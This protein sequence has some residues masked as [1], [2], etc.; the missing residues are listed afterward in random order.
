MSKLLLNDKTTHPEAQNTKQPALALPAKAVM[1]LVAG[2]CIFALSACGGSEDQWQSRSQGSDSAAVSTSTIEQAQQ[3]GRAKALSVDFLSQATR[4]STRNVAVNSVVLR[5]ASTQFMGTGALVKLRYN[6]IVIAD[7]EVTNTALANIQ[8]RVATRFDGGTLDLVFTNASSATG[9]WIR[10]MTVEAVSINGTG[11]SSGTAGVVYDLGHGLEAFDGIGVQRASPRLTATG[12]MR[13]PLPARSAIGA[14]SVGSADQLSAPPGA[15]VD[16]TAGTDSGPGI[17]GRPYRSLAALKGRAMLE[18]ENIYLRCGNKWRE[19]LTLGVSEISDG[20]QIIPFGDDCALAGKPMIT[21]AQSLNGGWT[22]SGNVWSKALPALTPQITRLFVGNTAMRP[23]QWPNADVPQALVEA[24]ITRQS[25]RFRISASAAAALAGKPIAGASLLLRTR[26]WTIESHKVASTGLEGNELT[27]SAVPRFAVDEGD[28]FILRDQAW[29]LDAPGEYF[30]DLINQRLL[31]IPAKAEAALDINSAEIEGSV[32]DVAIDIRGRS[33]LTIKGIAVSLARVDGIRMMDTPSA[34]LVDVEATDNGSAGIRLMQWLPITNETPG[35]SVTDSLLA[36]N[37]E[38]GI[39]ATFVRNARIRS[40][41]IVDTGTGIY[42]GTT[43]AALAIG[44]GGRAEGNQIEGSG[45]AGIMFS[46]L[47]GTMV[48]NNEISSY[49]LRLSDCGGIY[50]WTEIAMGPQAGGATVAGNRVL[51]EPAR[52]EPGPKALVDIKAGIY[53]DDFSHGVTVQDNLV[54]HAPTG[55]LVHNASRTTVFGNRLWMNSSSSLWITQDDVGGPPMLGNVFYNNTLVPRAM[56]Q[57]LGLD[58]PGFDVAHAFWLWDT[59]VGDQALQPARNH[60]FNNTVVQLYGHVA[61]YAWL[62]GPTSE[63]DVDAVEWQ[64]LNTS[65]QTVK[66]PVR[67]EVVMPVV[68]AERVVN[69]GFDGGMQSWIEHR[70]PA[71]WGGATQW[72][73][74]QAG[75][76]GACVGFTAGHAGDFQGSQTLM[77][78]PGV[79]H[80]YRLTATMPSSTSA[81]VGRPFISRQVSPWDQMSDARGYVSAHA[82][83]AAPGETLHYSAFFMPKAAAPSRVLLQLETLRQRVGLDNVSVREVLGYGLPAPGELS[84]VAVAP[85]DR[86]QQF[87][88]E[89]L[90]WPANC[91]ATDLSGMAVS[92]PITVA[93][94][95]EQ[96][97][98][99]MDTIF[100]R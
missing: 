34:T 61:A 58:L 79:P 27:A 20:A 28:T 42:T 89:D 11:F 18:G 95:K 63:R 48:L 30:H 14:A 16:L 35:P 96:F 8:F 40:N 73:T 19:T 55:I 49:C 80:V 97:L 88:C 17:S 64:A 7:A 24:A 5:V 39:D 71:G 90:G 25:S 22:R 13:I 1:L 2:L 87:Q 93:A 54:T 10:E 76:L 44:Q 75:C 29:M 77:M 38:Y 72:L 84:A 31:L 3:A 21:G 46:S 83:R 53:I 99:R 67:Y 41:Q 26:P 12:A 74:G 92:F 70:N 32:R 60:F 82:R 59:Q 85:Q 52:F 66:R 6:G 4:R 9:Q 50:T 47:Q 15:Y 45:Y 100:R 43:I 86:A 94:Q 62:R 23:A 78:R 57:T 68:G 56:A 98:L 37:G 36:G 65:A 69:S 51:A 33:D 91:A 81:T